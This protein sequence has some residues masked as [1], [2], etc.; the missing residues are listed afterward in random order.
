MSFL[1]Q[2]AK[3]FNTQADFFTQLSNISKSSRINIDQN[4]SA[5]DLKQKSS[6]EAKEEDFQVKKESFFTTAKKVF[7]EYKVKSDK[8]SDKVDQEK[9]EIKDDE[10]EIEKT[11][12]MIFGVVDPK[13][14]ELN[15][16]ENKNIDLSPAIEALK[17][18]TEAQELDP[19]LLDF[20]FATIDQ[21]LN[22]E[23][24]SLTK[25][26]ANLDLGTEEGVGE[27][28]QL[29]NQLELTR[30]LQERIE[31]LGAGLLE[32]VNE[33]A[34][35]T[36]TQGLSLELEAHLE[37]KID[38]KLSELKAQIDPNSQSQAA[39]EAQTAQLDESLN[40]NSSTEKD[41]FIEEGDIKRL[42]DK[43][44]DSIGA[45]KAKAENPNKANQALN[46]NFDAKIIKDVELKS[47]SGKSLDYTQAEVEILG[48][49][50][51]STSDAEQNTDFTNESFETLFP[52]GE[53]KV[54]NLKVK[55]LSKPVALKQLPEVI[56]KEIKDIK[57]NTKQ[58]LRMVL[59]PESLGKM[60]MSLSREDNQIHISMVVRTDEAATKLEQKI[61]DIK[62][63]L[64]DKGF[65]ANIE[66]TKS[67]ADNSN[68]SQFNQNHKQENET[69]QEQKEKYLNQAPEWLKYNGEGQSFNDTLN[70]TL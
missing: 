11:L 45:E 15:K 60:Q 9:S 17:T 8:N 29:S 31:A 24:E 59:N 38:L 46:N 62:L 23:I 18:R 20:F 2:L 27:I 70:Q 68:Q 51:T 28:L 67:D 10:D 22:G 6:F 36:E 66:V 7:N 19:E 63:A 26:I 39:K 52:K 44:K 56:G 48:I 16:I 3:T 40:L 4:S 53:V 55:S 35:T 69:K 33:A 42:L 34:K 37:E 5:L 57:P 30:E 1:D 54:S 13:Q 14:K 32:P 58:E 25:E 50:E 49:E 21:K 64:K 65:E 43:I 12:D 47:E 61:S 41:L